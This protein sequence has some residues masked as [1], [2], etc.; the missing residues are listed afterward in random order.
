MFAG[1]LDALDETIGVAPLAKPLHDLFRDAVPEVGGDLVVDGV[2]AHDQEPAVFHRQ[3]EQNPVAV[4]RTVQAEGIEGAPGGGAHIVA[5][6][7]VEADAD[8]PRGARL[9]MAHGR[10]DGVLLFVG[11][12][13]T[14]VSLFHAC[15]LPDLGARFPPA[16]HG[17]REGLVSVWEQRCRGAAPLAPKRAGMNALG[18]ISSFSLPLDDRYAHSADGWTGAHGAYT[19]I[20]EDA[21][22]A[23]PDGEWDVDHAPY[24][25]VDGVDLSTESSEVSSWS[26]AADDVPSFGQ[27]YA[28]THPYLTS[29]GVAR[30]ADATVGATSSGAPAQAP[31]SDLDDAFEEDPLDAVDTPSEFNA[32]ATGSTSL[33]IERG[34]GPR[35]HGVPSSTTSI[36][37]SVPG[38]DIHEYVVFP[39]GN[40]TLDIALPELPCGE[41][42]VVIQAFAG[43]TLVGRGEFVVNVAPNP[44]E[45]GAP[46]SPA[47][48]A[49]KKAGLVA[50]AARAE[51]AA[52]GREGG[53]LPVD[54]AR[55]SPRSSEPPLDVDEALPAPRDRWSDD[56][57]AAVSRKD[58]SSFAAPL[59]ASSF[60]SFDDDSRE[61]KQP[62]SPLSPSGDAGSWP[63]PRSAASSHASSRATPPPIDPI[64]VRKAPTTH[65]NPAEA[66][67]VPGQ[68]LAAEL[69]ASAGTVA[70]LL[71]AG[72]GSEAR[73]ARLGIPL[74][75]EGSMEILSGFHRRDYAKVWHGALKSEAGAV[76]FA[77]SLVASPLLVAL[78]ALLARPYERGA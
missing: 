30:L 54:V 75:L 7:P 55:I 18:S 27:M 32:T 77:G 65:D 52:R 78:G 51:G 74:V 62:S 28:A 69:A 6:P 45:G 39:E 16:L 5:R 68:V 26:G 61:V 25:E 15:V 47:A 73:R 46:A 3:V 36:I 66:S 42:D 21:Q 70:P 64:G 9:G 2:V 59:A 53:A 13:I 11:E 67:Y 48:D 71:S 72:A 14:Q 41:Q 56:H 4:L 50:D 24:S 35:G 34:A 22:Y 19:D 38:T 60:Q 12:E 33:T 43:T 1:P 49:A 17:L 8:V 63:G 37:V 44:G 23:H 40:P 10:E 76:I 57:D 31:C 20:A 58:V 29:E